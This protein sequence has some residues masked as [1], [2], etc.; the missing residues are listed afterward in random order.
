MNEVN[1]IEEQDYKTRHATA[2]HEGLIEWAVKSGIAKDSK[3]AQILLLCC[4]I[5]AILIAIVVFVMAMP[6]TIELTPRQEAVFENTQ[7]VIPRR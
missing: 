7:F 2:K 5:T 3:S 1:F 6:R 4:A